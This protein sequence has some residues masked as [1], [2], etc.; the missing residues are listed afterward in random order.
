MNRTVEMLVYGF[1]FISHVICIRHNF[2]WN[3]KSIAAVMGSVLKQIKLFTNRVR[4]IAT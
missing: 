4:P 3:G 2:G 1:V